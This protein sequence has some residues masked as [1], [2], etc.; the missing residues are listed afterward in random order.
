MNIIIWIVFGAIVGWIATKLTSTDAS[1]GITANILI[2]IAGAF[3]GGYIM[4]KMGNAGVEGFNVRSFLVAI[5]GSTILLIVFRM[6][7]GRS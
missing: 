4:E 2:G 5:L 3:I 1:Y 6:I 7:R